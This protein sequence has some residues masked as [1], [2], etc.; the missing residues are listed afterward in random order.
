MKVY[1]RLRQ[2]RIDKGITQV[3]IASKLK[4]P[5]Q[6]FNAIELGRIKLTA[7]EF[8]EIC[9]K[10]YEVSPSIFFDH[11]FLETKNNTEQAS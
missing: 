5:I 1:E 4:K 7:D 10:G 6:R 9:I 11:Q 8:E 2:Y 3:H